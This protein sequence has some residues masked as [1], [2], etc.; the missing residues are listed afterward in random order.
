MNGI[1]EYGNAAR[2]VKIVLFVSPQNI[3]PRQTYSK[4]FMQ[5]ENKCITA[6][7]NGVS[8]LHGNALAFVKVSNTR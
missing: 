5:G 3:L 6:E 4:I 2:Q 8:L 7:E 1:T